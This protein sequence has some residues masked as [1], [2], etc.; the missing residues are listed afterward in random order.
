MKR[1]GFGFLSIVLFLACAETSVLAQG[2]YT[3]GSCNYNDV[4][5]CINSGSGSCSPSTHTAVNGDVINIPSGSCSWSTGIV[6]PSNIGI[7]VAGDGTPNSDP[8][9]T[10]ASSSCGSNTTITVTNAIT[11]FKMAPQS[12][13]STSRLSC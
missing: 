11:A 3:A 4:N 8:S 6:V 7:T 9:E 10:G 2:T 13:N 5:A 12:G 1:L